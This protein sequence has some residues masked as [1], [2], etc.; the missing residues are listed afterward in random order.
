[1]AALMV[2]LFSVANHSINS[3]TV[4]RTSG[5]QLKGFSFFTEIAFCKNETCSIN[6]YITGLLQSCHWKSTNFKIL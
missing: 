5:K 6:N 1:M 4:A 3:L 2:V